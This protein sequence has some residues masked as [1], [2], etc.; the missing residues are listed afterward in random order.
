L[1]VLCLSLGSFLFSFPLFS[2]FVRASV[3]ACIV[4][5]EGCY[6]D[7][8]SF[9]LNRDE[10]DE[11]FALKRRRFWAEAVILQ[12]GHWNYDILQSGPYS[13]KILFFF[14]L[15]P[16]SISI[17]NFIFNCVLFKKLEGDRLMM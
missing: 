1:F 6:H 8:L 5:R 2:F 17:F 14:N 4:G 9:P 13:R 11:Q 3:M 12:F 16:R 7:L 10:G 15:A